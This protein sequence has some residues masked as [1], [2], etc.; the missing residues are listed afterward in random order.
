M[1]RDTSNL[2]LFVES[3]CSDHR[4]LQK[5]DISELKEALT[6]CPTRIK[7]SA[8]DSPSGWWVPISFYN[9]INGNR[10][11][12]N[13]KLWENVRDKQKDTWCGS[14]MLCDHPS[15]DSDGNP[16]DI[17]GVW[18]DMKLGDPDYS[19]KGLVYGLLMPSGRNGEDLQSHLQNGLKIGT[20]SSGFGKLMSD[21][22][23][24]DP[25]TYV[26]ERLADWVL[27]PSQGTFFSYD[28]NLGSI[29]DRSMRESDED[30]EDRIEERSNFI[31]SIRDAAKRY[32][33]I[34]PDAEMDEVVDAV[35]NTYPEEGFTRETVERFVKDYY[36][37]ESNNTKETIM[38]DSAKLTK[39]E[40]KKFRR[41]ME[42]FLESA[43]SIRDP[44]ERLEELKDIREYFEDGACPDLREKV[45]Q[46]ITEQEALIKQMLS[47]RLEMKE[48]LGVDSVRELKEKLTQ[49]AEDTKNAQNDAKNYKQIAEQLQNKLTEATNNLNSRP[50]NAYVSYQKEQIS[51]LKE[52]LEEH[53]T[54]AADVIKSL[55]ESYKTLKEQSDC[56]SAELDEI[57]NEKADLE[58][59][60]K[61]YEEKLAN[62]SESLN[63]ARNSYT[64]LA[65][66]YKKAMKELDLFKKLIEK[67]RALFEKAI[68]SNEELVESNN[69]KDNKIET[70]NSRFD[71]TKKALR[72][73]LSQR[74]DEHVEDKTD[75]ER[76]FESLR[77]IYGS[78][79]DAYRSLIVDAVSLA[80]AKK[81]FFSDVINNLSESKEIER[82]RL[83]ESMTMSMEE[84][85]RK[86]TKKPLVKTSSLS[87]MPKG[88]K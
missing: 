8:S 66:K 49:V 83:P 74:L 24:V 46:K 51:S 85:A 6:K 50:T 84:R 59:N 21:G 41:D 78:E 16:K 37:N 54:Q 70:L 25:D 31:G 44:Q 23:T 29:Q 63:K 17:C 52:T 72:E 15:G 77:Q 35:I 82:M 81:V 48:E 19:G 7:E 28:E 14:A 68:K 34:H 39:L 80:E 38:K 3:A 1:N 57:K 87:R 42:S 71:H 22:V 60:I 65:E 45:E 88:W 20:S 5:A 62:I 30:S 53:D 11:N 2:T 61:A 73:S 32:M 67:N 36:M 69:Q 33:R 58:G 27:N 64:S 18:L 79:L 10:R 75:T 55:S 40:E 47:E 86:I 26:I 4:L 56:T 9:K 13:K 43:N 76:Y 12:Y